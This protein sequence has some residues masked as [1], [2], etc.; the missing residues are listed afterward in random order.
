MN[1]VMCPRCLRDL[2]GNP[3]SCPHEGC[4]IKLPINYVRECMAAP[5]IMLAT[6]GF[7]QVGIFQVWLNSRILFSPLI[8]ALYTLLEYFKMFRICH[9]FKLL[10]SRDSKLFLFR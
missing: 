10:L 4:R 7:T 8:P 6:F 5:P 9:G 2:S 3:A 1:D